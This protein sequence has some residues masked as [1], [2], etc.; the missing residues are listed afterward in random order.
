M[1]NLGL[2][3]A[4][5]QVAAKAFPWFQ[6]L[7]F[8]LIGVLLLPVVT[9]TFIRTMV[10]QKSNARNLCVLS[11]YTLIDII[12][13]FLLVGAALTSW[14][15]VLVFIVAIGIAIGYNIRIMTFAVKLE[16]D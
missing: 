9:I 12:L 6:R 16:E 15:A 13:A 11:V 3:P 1:L 8:W 4:Q 10:R 14:L 2:L 5:M 7:L